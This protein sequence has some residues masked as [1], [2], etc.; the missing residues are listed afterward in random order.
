MNDK[1]LLPKRTKRIVYETLDHYWVNYP[2]K[3]SF[4]P[5]NQISSI[6]W[7]HKDIELGF[8]TQGTVKVT[9]NGKKTNIKEGI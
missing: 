3:L 4:G 5:K 6:D 2:Y 1:L 8:V 7:I 9:L